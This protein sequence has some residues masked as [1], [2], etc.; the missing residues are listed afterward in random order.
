MIRE[1]ISLKNYDEAI[2][3]FMGDCTSCT[4]TQ[5]DWEPWFTW[6]GCDIHHP[7]SCLGQDVIDVH[8]WNPKTKEVEDLGKI[9]Q[10][11][12]CYITNGDL[13]EFIEEV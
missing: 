5:D 9:C 1:K 8:G 4:P 2:Q 11:C 3:E 7:D 12:L 10:D 13:P 6:Y